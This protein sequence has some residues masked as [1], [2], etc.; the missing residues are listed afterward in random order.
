MSVVYSEKV[1]P[2]TH[3]VHNSIMITDLATPDWGE[4][5]LAAKAI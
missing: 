1:H 5:M 3:V 2:K 4:A